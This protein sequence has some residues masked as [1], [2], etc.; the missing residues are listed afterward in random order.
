MFSSSPPGKFSLALVRCFLSSL[1]TARRSRGILTVFVPCLFTT[2]CTH[3]ISIA[4]TQLRVVVVCLVLSPSYF[5]L[6]VRVCAYDMRFGLRMYKCVLSNTQLL[7]STRADLTLCYI[8]SELYL[9]KQNITHSS[10][11]RC[12]PYSD[13]LLAACSFPPPLLS[14]SLRFVLFSLLI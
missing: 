2:Y 9:N 6:D 11:L 10:E 13:C 14:F 8:L 4:C 5:A 12:G 3:H 7:V 1:H